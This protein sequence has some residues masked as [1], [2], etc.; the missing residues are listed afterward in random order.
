MQERAGFTDAFGLGRRVGIAA[1][2][3]RDTW[4]FMAGLF[5]GNINDTAERGRLGCR[6]AGARGTQSTTIDLTV[7]L[8]GSLRYRERGKDPKPASLSPTP[9]RA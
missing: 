2:T 5:A 1:S 3:R 9:F 6:G 7:H 4:T 8:G